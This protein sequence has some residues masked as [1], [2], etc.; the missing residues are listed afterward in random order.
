[1]RV[2][3]VIIL[4]YLCCDSNTLVLSC[5]S[6]L[7]PQF[8]LIPRKCQGSNLCN[9]YEKCGPQARLMNMTLHLESFVELLPGAK[10]DG[11][12][13][14]FYPFLFVISAEFIIRFFALGI[15]VKKWYQMWLLN[16]KF[17]LIIKEIRVYPLLSSKKRS[18]KHGLR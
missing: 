16:F 9:F 3:T 15:A 7:A 18:Q 5:F 10:K 13:L 1:M 2:G 8:Q 14:C 12:C 11:F 6:P 4:Q 17:S